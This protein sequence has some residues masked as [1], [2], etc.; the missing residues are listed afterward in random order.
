MTNLCF[1]HVISWFGISKSAPVSSSVYFVSSYPQIL[2]WLSQSRS[3]LTFILLLGLGLYFL[4]SI[5]GMLIMSVR[6]LDAG[7][8]PLLLILSRNSRPHWTSGCTAGYKKEIDSFWLR[9]FDSLNKS[10]SDTGSHTWEKV[11]DV[12]LEAVTIHRTQVCFVQSCR[13]FLSSATGSRV[14][15]NVERY[16]HFFWRPRFCSRV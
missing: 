11:S 9:G 14:R 3:L 6:A 1:T 13:M 10:L 15:R 8:R 2:M 4:A 16:S 5:K 7:R 12:R